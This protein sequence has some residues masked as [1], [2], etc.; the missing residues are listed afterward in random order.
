MPETL[1]EWFTRHLDGCN[2]PLVA[3]RLCVSRQ[4]LY[5]YQKGTIKPA[6]P[7]LYAF[8]TSR[9]VLFTV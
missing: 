7:R 1:A 3:E 6:L 2:L 8:S 5:A 9:G 4:T